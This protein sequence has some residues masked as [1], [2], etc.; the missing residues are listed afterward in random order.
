MPSCSAQENF[1]YGGVEN[2]AYTNS[3]FNFSMN[4]PTDWVVQS[5][6]R[7]EDITRKGREMVAGKDKNL[8]N[9]I[10]AAEV[11]TAQLLMLYQHEVGAAV[12]YNPSLVLV[13]E[14]VGHAP[15]IKTGADYLFHAR[16]LLENAQIQYNYIDKEFEQVIINGKEFYLMNAHVNYM[17]YDIKQQYYSTLHKG[18][19]FNVII[20]YVN[21]DQQSELEHSVGSMEFQL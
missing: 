10:K 18:F 20:S 17:G 1:D 13:A 19:C 12:D 5:K 4:L 14:N 16:K 7:V 9:A 15:G 6:E 8:E 2:N 3:F 21:E 11:N